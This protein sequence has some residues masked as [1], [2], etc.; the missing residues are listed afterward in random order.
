MHF[1]IHA[2]TIY[3]TKHFSN[4]ITFQIVNNYIMKTQEISMKSHAVSCSKRQIVN[5]TVLEQRTYHSLSPCVALIAAAYMANVW[6][7]ILFIAVCFSTFALGICT[8]WLNWCV[9]LCLC[10]IECVLGCCCVFLSLL[11]VVCLNGSVCHIQ[12]LL[13]LWDAIATTCNQFR[14]NDEIEAK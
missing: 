8:N 12:I 10:E 14:Y 7:W 1:H 3:S 13:R 5:N 4:L 2:S 11:F 6:R 9:R